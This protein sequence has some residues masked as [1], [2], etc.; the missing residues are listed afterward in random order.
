MAAR[1]LFS[2]VIAVFL[3]DSLMLKVKS[4]EDLPVI[5]CN[6]E[7]LECR[8]GRCVPE[9]WVCDGEDDCGDESDEINCDPDELSTCQ[10]EEFRCAMGTCIPTAWQCDGEKDCPEEDALDEWDQLCKNERCSAGEFRCEAEGACIP[11][12]WICD[13]HPDCLDGSDELSCNVT[14]GQE[15]F[16]CLDRNCIQAR[17][18]C[19]GE[20]DCFDES[21]EANCIKTSCDPIE[22][23]ACDSGRCVNK[24][25]RCDGEMDCNDGSDEKGC[26]QQINSTGKCDKDSF[27]C[28]NKEECVN[29]G[30]LCDG[31]ADCADGSDEAEETCGAKSKCREDQFECKS[32][33]CIPLHLRC[34]ES[35]E[36]LDGSDEDSCDMSMISTSPANTCDFSSEF[37]CMES[38][39]CIP[40]DRVCDRTND[41]GNW[42]DENSCHY[43]ECNDNNGGCDHICV[44]TAASFF[45]DCRHGFTLSHNSTCTDLNECQSLIGSCSQICRNTIGSFECSCLDGF[46]PDKSNPNKCVVAKGKVG[47]VFSHQTDI[48]LLDVSRKEESIIV[49]ETRSVTAL[50]YHLVSNLVFWTDSDEKVIF[51][52]NINKMDS[53][54]KI[55]LDG[56]IGSGDGIAVDWV[57]DNIYWT[58]GIRQT[59]SV[60]KLDG[61]FITDV[62]DEELE[63]PRS[64]AVFPMRGLM[65]WSDWGNVPKI[66]KAGMD[67][68]ER[69]VLATDNVMWPNGISI[70]LVA[71]R[72]YWVDAKLHIIASVMLDGSGS[73]IITEQ[74]SSLN[75]PFSV[76]V[77]EDWVYWT[78]WIQNGSSIFRANKFNGTDIEKLVEAK[79]HHKPMSLQVYHSQRQPLSPN[80][81]QERAMTCSHICVPSPQVFRPN[82]KEIQYATT[83]L[84]PLEYTKHDDGFNCV[85][86]KMSESK[87]KLKKEEQ[88]K[89]TPNAEVEEIISDTIKNDEGINYLL[90]AVFGTLAVIVPLIILA[91]VI[92]YKKRL[93]SDPKGLKYALS[94][95]SSP[96]ACNPPES[97]SMLTGEKESSV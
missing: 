84:C 62:V 56:N 11:E 74:S 10:P 83:C 30:W 39:I 85:T 57:Y 12:T 28:H 43:N 65:F 14:C 25:W 80:L 44:D 50:D 3:L 88:N 7:E 76:S 45:C 82:M 92:I 18:R 5:V 23:M 87:E 71:E 51:R 58:N 29:S 19:D 53:A 89:N 47:I 41:C 69:V 63:K 81:C 79:M 13:D 78:E 52:A 16:Q 93:E 20:K 94:T 35:I 9:S 31:D 27:A 26:K 55:V 4:N 36:C 17:W 42:E 34:S 46:L 8:N 22:E 59:I 77:L 91:G 49:K 60:S 72:L 66:E 61:S 64:I 96:S 90:V 68:T 86:K 1:R 6:T 67:G 75:H 97:E 48:R 24:R 38:N 54:K 70:D 32:G 15:E 21:D 95:P 33:E 73:F 40:L 2:A 37:S